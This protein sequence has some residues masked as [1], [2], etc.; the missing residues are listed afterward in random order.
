MKSE[1][2]SNMRNIIYNM[3]VVKKNTAIESMQNDAPNK[4][5]GC[6]RV[7]INRRSE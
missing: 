5:E 1:K 4:F 2:A 7:D 3:D 6:L